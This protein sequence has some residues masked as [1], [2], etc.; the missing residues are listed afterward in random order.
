MIKK[1]RQPNYHTGIEV[2]K[3]RVAQLL[4]ISDER[5]TM[6]DDSSGN[7]SRLDF[8]I[9][10]YSRELTQFLPFNVKPWVRF[11]FIKEEE[12]EETNKTKSAY[13]IASA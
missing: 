10:E 3:I 1:R 6:N 11:N 4:N 12:E 7:L 13:G 9:F 8:H 5:W 2:I